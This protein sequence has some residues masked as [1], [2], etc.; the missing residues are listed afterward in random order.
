MLPV[1]SHF[2]LTLYYGSNVYA[3]CALCMKISFVFFCVM[4][5][6]QTHMLLEKFPQ[7]KSNVLTHTWL[8]WILYCLQDG[9]LH[10]QKKALIWNFILNQKM[11]NA[12]FKFYASL[13]DP[14]VC[15]RVYK[16]YYHFMP[17][18]PHARTHI[19]C[20]FNRL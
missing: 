4:E 7:S 11:N 2:S 15:I 13:F 5:V 3:L 16:I 14:R 20:E 18:Q 17:S 6:S 8:C 19:H 1:V 9:I 12:H 10:T